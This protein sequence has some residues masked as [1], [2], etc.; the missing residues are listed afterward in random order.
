MANKLIAWGKIDPTENATPEALNF[1]IATLRY[2]LNKLGMSPEEALSLPAKKQRKCQQTVY[3]KSYT[4]F[5]A[6]CRAKL[7]ENTE[8]YLYRSLRRESPVKQSMANRPDFVE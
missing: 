7:I 4:S 2:Q 1:P 5:S 3:G 6:A 8:P